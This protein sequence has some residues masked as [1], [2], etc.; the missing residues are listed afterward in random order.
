[1][2]TWDGGEDEHP[3]VKA[4]RL[5]LEEVNESIRAYEREKARLEAESKQAGVRGLT[6]KHTLAQLAASPLAERLNTALIK[7]EAAVRK[8]TKM[9]GNGMVPGEATETSG[10]PSQGTMFWMSA[11]LEV[12]KNLYGR[13]ASRF[14]GA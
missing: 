13:R 14:Q 12:K 11:D 2:R 9:F 6:A 8:A 5:A 4:A 7:A 10:K 1:M 3:L